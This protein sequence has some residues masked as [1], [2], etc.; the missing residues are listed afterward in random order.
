MQIA[1]AHQIGEGVELLCRHRTGGNIRNS[2]R[3]HLL[4]TG[5]RFPYFARG[6]R[7]IPINI[8]ELEPESAEDGDVA[9]TL[10]IFQL[11]NF[12]SNELVA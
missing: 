10:E 5:I 2:T 8:H 12:S 6:F 3:V 7:H 4:A 9:L 11:E 1:R